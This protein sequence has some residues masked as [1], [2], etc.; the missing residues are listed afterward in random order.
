MHL[1]AAFFTMPKQ[2]ENSRDNADRYAYNFANNQ[3]IIAL[4]D[5][6]T[7]SFFPQ[8]WALIITEYFVRKPLA[9][10]EQILNDCHEKWIDKINQQVELFGN[11]YSRR[12]LKEKRPA[13]ATLV[14]LHFYAEN[15][16]WYWNSMVNGDSF[17]IFIPEN[18]PLPDVIESSLDEPYIFDNFPPFLGSYNQQK[19]QLKVRTR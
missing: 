14:G 17:L 3:A 9:T 15:D 8:D 16:H 2:L 12:M 1:Q 19:L 6:V 10:I 5:G 13:A 11:Y 7:Q 4:A 18:N